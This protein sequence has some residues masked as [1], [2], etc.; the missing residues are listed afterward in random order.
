MGRLHRLAQALG[1]EVGHFFADMNAEGRG[2]AEPVEDTRSQ[3]RRLLELVHHAANIRDRGR[4]EAIC[5]L[6]RELAALGAG[7]NPLVERP[8]P[9]SAG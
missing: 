5:Q 2:R 9:P 8:Q 7:A 3:R 1:V 6:A 4:R